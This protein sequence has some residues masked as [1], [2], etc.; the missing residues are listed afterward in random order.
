MPKTVINYSGAYTEQS[1][2]DFLADP[3]T[4]AFC[5][6]LTPHPDSIINDPI[7]ATSHT[8]DLVLP[9][10]GALV[11]RRIGGLLPTAIDTEAGSESAGLSYRA[12]FDDTAI[13]PLQ[14]AEGDWDAAQL[15]IYSINYKALTMGQFIEFS[16]QIGGFTEEGIVWEA[17]A[18][19]LT[20]LARIKVGRRASANCDVR[21]FG[22]P[23]R[24]KKSLAALTH[25]GAV[26]TTGASQDTFRASALPA[27]VLV[28][29]LNGTVTF[30]TGQNAGRSRVVRSWNPANG[31]ITL[32]KALPFTIAV[33]DQFTAVEGCDRSANGPAGCIAHNNI[34]NFQGLRFITNVEKFNQ[35]IRAI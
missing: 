18:R 27:A 30:T 14:L 12:I 25:T 29:M 35:I 15:D 7:G 20:A 1:L 21:V 11:F 9:G 32:Q 33:S 22:D 3:V 2:H 8:R 4:Q 19:P 16:G 13:T 24:C 17:Q 26:V 5:W 10:H 34:I 28:S 6:K 31:E 23:K